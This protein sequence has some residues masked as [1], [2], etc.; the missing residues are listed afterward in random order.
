MV[1][2]LAG[3]MIF[4]ACVSTG[5]AR[6]QE[7][8]LSKMYGRGV[9]AYFDGRYAQAD[10]SLS[11]A[12]DAGSR[13]PRCYYFRGLCR[14]RL[15]RNDEARADFQEGARLESRGT[16]RFY[17]VSRALERVQ[18]RSRVSVERFR[19]QG[20]VEA[21]AE[22]SR[23]RQLRYDRI[24]RN[25]AEVLGTPVPDTI[26][27]DLAPPVLDVTLPPAPDATSPPGTRSSA[28]AAVEA[29]DTTGAS[30]PANTL[31]DIFTRALLKAMSGGEEESSLPDL[32]PTLPLDDDDPFGLGDDATEEE[33][34]IDAADSDDP[35]GDDAIVEDATD[36]PPSPKNP[37]LLDDP[38]GGD[39]SDESTPD[40]SPVPDDPFG[41]DSET[42]DATDDE[43]D[44]NDPFGGDDS[45]PDDVPPEDESEGFPID[46]DDPFA[47]GS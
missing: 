15:G 5:S 11:G 18:G 20:R 13:D 8:V 36:E 45:T 9:H 14:V 38:F 24:D 46:P 32:P 28:A 21:V 16:A 39:P 27:T 35:F 23:I 43:V 3:L 22:S 30:V 6:A 33:M 26:P 1:C 12:I 10:R 42:D 25:E 4:A 17:D 31:Q 47:P 40:D 37:P 29:I 19:T 7:G 2:R 34:P 44:P 41:D